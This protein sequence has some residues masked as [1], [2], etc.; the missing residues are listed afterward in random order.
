MTALVPTGSVGMWSRRA[1]PRI[2]ISVWGI[3]DAARPALHSHA[4]RGNEE[5]RAK[6]SVLQ[7]R[8]EPDLPGFKNLEGLHIVAL[9]DS[10]A[11]LLVPKLQLGNSVREAP[12]SRLAKLELCSLGSQAGAWE[13]A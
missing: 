1:A 12:A 9:R 5:T 8:C 4:A 13:P 3:R 7:E 10:F 6:V 2:T 11:S